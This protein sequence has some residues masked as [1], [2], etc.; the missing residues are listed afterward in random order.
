[1]TE[2]LRAAAAR[3]ELAFP[4]EILARVRQAVRTPA[5]S[6]LGTLLAL[7]RPLVALPAAAIV[8]A[9]IWLASP[10]G[11]P[12]GPAPTIDAFY[13]FEQHAA[14]EARAPFAERNVAPT[15]LE[16]AFD[17]SADGSPATMPGILAVAAGPFNVAR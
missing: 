11:H 17:D 6:P 15:I 2:V 14:D 8:L 7:W 16:T 4:P 12:A 13:F 3:D 5:R 10:L 9:A 1:L